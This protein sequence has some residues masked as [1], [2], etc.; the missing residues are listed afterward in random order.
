ME[1]EEIIAVWVKA[2]IER[3]LKKPANPKMPDYVVEW[4]RWLDK[5][6]LHSACEPGECP[7]PSPV[8]KWISD[9]IDDP[10]WV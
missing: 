10:D 5:V 9:T 3:R 6:A 1:P 4:A 2:R 8:T 7:A